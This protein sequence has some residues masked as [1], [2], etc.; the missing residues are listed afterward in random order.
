MLIRV[1]AAL[2]CLVAATV[3][4]A[5]ATLTGR[6]VGVNDGDTITLLDAS[7]TQHR[8]RLAGIDAPERGQPGGYRSKESLAKLVY[9]Q[10]VRVESNKRDRYDRIVGKVWVAAPD[11]PCR[12]KPECPKTLDAGLALITMGRAWGFRQDADEQSPE[13]RERYEFA[14]QE[15]RARKAGLWRDGTAVPPWKWRASKNRDS[16]N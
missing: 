6:V 5:Q 10:Q 3:V 14:E 11:S 16:G 7:K 15:A 12:G 8:V 4:D 2:A 9:D 1:A 13:D